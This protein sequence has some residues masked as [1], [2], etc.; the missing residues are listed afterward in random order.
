MGGSFTGVEELEVEEELD[1]F[2][3]V[4]W[5]IIIGGTLTNGILYTAKIS[6]CFVSDMTVSDD[7]GLAVVVSAEQGI[8]G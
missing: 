4:G 7:V 6:D 3:A 5:V 8:T 1:M 2:V